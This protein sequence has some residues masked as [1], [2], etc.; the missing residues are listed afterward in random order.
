M[1]SVCAWSI[2][3][4]R[5]CGAWRKGRVRQIER[6]VDRMIVIFP[7]EETFYR[8]HGVPVTYVGHPLIEQLEH[9]TGRRAIPP[10]CASPCCPARGAWK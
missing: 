9:I 1:S 8:Q 5:S 10:C 7:F 3:S 2:T 6:Y 4:L